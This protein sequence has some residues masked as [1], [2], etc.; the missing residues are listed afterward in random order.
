MQAQPPATPASLA[1]RLS[2]PSP[3]SKHPE[4][5]YRAATLLAVLLLLWSAAA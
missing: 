3:V 4:Y 5:V 2:L 1:S